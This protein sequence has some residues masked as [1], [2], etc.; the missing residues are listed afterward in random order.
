MMAFKN[1]SSSGNNTFQ[2]YTSFLELYNEDINDLLVVPENTGQFQD[3]HPAIREDMNGNI[4]WAGI[5]EQRVHTVNDLIRYTNTQK[6][7]ERHV[8]NKQYAP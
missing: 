1:S 8:I 3:N 2:I 4:Y 7:Y 5:K 6:D